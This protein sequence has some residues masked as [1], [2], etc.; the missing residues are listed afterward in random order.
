MKRSAKAPVALLR[1]ETQ[2]TCCAASI[3]S[4]LRAHGKDQTEADVNKV[5]GASPMSGATWEAMLATVQYFGLRGSLVVPSTVAQ[6]KKWTDAGIPVVIAWNPEGRPW[7]HASCVFDVDD[8][9]N[10]HVM[11]PN[12]P[13]PSR[14]VRIV[15]EDEFYGK[16]YEAVG[17]KLIVRRPA[18]AVEREV[19]ADGRQVM[20]GKKKDDDIALRGR[21]RREV[22]KEQGRGGLPGSWLG[23]GPHRDH[24]KYDRDREKDVDR[25]DEEEGRGK[26][27]SMTRTSD[28]LSQPLSTR[29]DYGAVEP[30]SA[31]EFRNSLSKTA[32]DVPKDVERYLKEVKE[33]NSD[34]SDKQAWATAWSIYCK[35]KNPGSSHCKKETSEYFPGKKASS[36]N[37]PDDVLR[38]MKTAADG[39]DQIWIVSDPERDAADIEDVFYQ[40]TVMN[41]V[42]WCIET[43]VSSWKEDHTAIY[44]SKAEALRDARSRLVMRD[45]RL[46]SSHTA[47]NGPYGVWYR[48]PGKGAPKTKNFANEAAATNW[49]EKLREKEGDDVEVRYSFPEGSSKEAKFERGRSMSVDDVSEVVGPEFKKMNEDPPESVAKLKEEMSGKTA[50]RTTHLAADKS[51][52]TLCGERAYKDSVVDSVKDATCFYCKQAWDKTHGGKTANERLSIDAFAE[53]LKDSKFEKGK[54]V[55]V[56]KLPDEL[57]ENVED[58]PPSVKK[59]TDELKGKKASRVVAPR[60]ILRRATLNGLITLDESELPNFKD[61]ARDAADSINGSWPEVEGFGSSDMMSVLKE[62]LDVAGV[63]NAYVGNRLT[64]LAAEKGSSLLL[65]TDDFAESLKEGKFEK[66]KPAD[67]TKN[68]S[69]AD[70]AEWK[71]QNDEHKDNFKG[72]ST[73]AQKSDEENDAVVEQF[74]HKE[75]GASGKYGFTKATET[76]CGAGVTRLQKTA[77]RLAKALYAKDEGS[78]AF[79]SKHASKGAS[80]TAAMLLKAMEGIGPMASLGKTAGKSGN[81]LYGFTEKTAKLG[82]TACNE[83][84]HEA[85]IIASDLASRKGSDPVKVAGYLS[86]HA[87]KAKCPY[88]SMLAECSADAPAAS[89]KASDFLASDEDEVDEVS[90]IVSKC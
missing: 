61:A 28:A 47:G 87:K 84:H 30:L 74:F 19:T 88:A 85:G 2:F 9:H 23:A 17:D 89:K 77:T 73:P 50:A 59:L 37:L 86:A 32:R 52:F 81:G 54:S 65:A 49:V 11:D 27:A 21:V 35:N 70:A 36:M 79:L 39:H 34:Y 29:R 69:E 42:N 38:L 15:S 46:A 18:M 12:V 72:A 6:L 53:L 63:R 1:Q 3:A 71:R 75:A 4:A 7:S 83:L 62:F 43:G 25:D 45:A 20:A 33:K 78:P 22:F 16:W 80:K 64:R 66:D 31:E 67:P 41:L 56:S 57:Q 76:S 14:S 10:V 58:P 68:M 60:D 13:N 48:I 90:D 8:N 82:L 5:L 51:G 44:L 40:T 26:Y 55:P 24:S